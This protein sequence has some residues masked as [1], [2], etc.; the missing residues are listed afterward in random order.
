[1]K[2]HKQ[3]VKVIEDLRR[4][5]IQYEGYE[6]HLKEID[7]G[8]N[9]LYWQQAQKELQDTL[10]E[11]TNIIIKISSGVLDE[12]GAT[13]MWTENRETIKKVIQ[14]ASLN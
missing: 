2:T 10:C 11:I 12:K 14:I 4:L 9:N 8:R 5:I 3:R 6:L 7:K 13:K 1:M